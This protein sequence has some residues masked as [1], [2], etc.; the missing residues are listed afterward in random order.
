MSYH[1]DSQLDKTYLPELKGRDIQ[2]YSHK[3]SVRFLSYGPWLAE[4]RKPDFFFQP[5]IVLRKILGRKLHGTFL[6]KQYALD[7]SLYIAISRLGDNSLLLHILGILLS[8][9]GAW[10]LRNKFAIYDTL[11]PWYTKKQL[12][13]FPMKEKDNRLI[14]IVERM[15]ELNRELPKAKTPDEKTRLERQITATDRQ[16]DKLV[17]ELYGLTEDEIKIMEGV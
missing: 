14:S 2:R 4:P 11:Y 12:S 8:T 16:I 15:L 10:Y 17:Y 3:K 9:L 5:K 7:Q 6:D 13:A 1:A